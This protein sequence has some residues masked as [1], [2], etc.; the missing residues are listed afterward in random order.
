MSIGKYMAREI[1]KELDSRSR[2]FY[3][4]VLPAIDIVEDNNE[5][6][7]MIDLPGFDKKDIHL[8]I[9]GNIL[10]ISA[11]RVSEATGTVYQRHRPARI[12]K[13]VAL[14]ISVKEDEKI[15][16]KATYTDGVVVLRIPM[17]TTSTSIP[18]T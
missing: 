17:A 18:I 10:S 7:V 13:K 2:E 12:E 1:A 4:F 5:L 3:E 8:K 9:K 15:V 16:G 11:K 6:A 14:P